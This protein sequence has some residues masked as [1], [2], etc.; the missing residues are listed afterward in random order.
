MLWIVK[1]PQKA[2]CQWHSELFAR[3]RQA[4]W[5]SLEVQPHYLL[6]T[7]IP[8]LSNANE[9]LVKIF[10][11]NEEVNLNP[12]TTP[13]GRHDSMYL[14]SGRERFHLIGRYNPT[15]GRMDFIRDWKKTRSRSRVAM[16]NFWKAFA[17]LGYFQRFCLET[18]FL[19]IS[20]QKS[21]TIWEVHL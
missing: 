21:G 6:G 4:P 9:A 11:V 19:S 5:P 17:S 10:S 8:F 18:A 7:T 12:D 20:T 3:A 2:K 16:R 14:L 1:V 13:A 15:L